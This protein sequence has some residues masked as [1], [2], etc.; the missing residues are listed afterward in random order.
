MG[1]KHAHELTPDEKQR[2][3][4]EKEK[5]KALAKLEKEQVKREK[6]DRKRGKKSSKKGD[7]SDAVSEAGSAWSDSTGS[8]PGSWYH[9]VSEPASLRSSVYLPTNSGPKSYQHDCW[10]SGY[11]DGGPDKSTSK[12]ASRASSKS[13]DVLNL[14]SGSLERYPLGV[15]TAEPI[16]PIQRRNSL[17]LS[18]VNETNVNK[19]VD[20]SKDNPVKSD[21]AVCHRNTEYQSQL[22]RPEIEITLPAPDQLTERN[23]RKWDAAEQHSLQSSIYYSADDGSSIASKRRSVETSSLGSIYYS[24]DEGSLAGSSLAGSIYYSATSGSEVGERNRIIEEE[25]LDAGRIV[26][27]N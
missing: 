23:K 16:D 15:P 27:S 22:T 3:K 12:P 26:F 25:F 8:A 24:A 7:G 5:E 17:D 2:L 21:S 19:G 20:E 4:F 11:E 9:S 10:Y 6:Q 13:H 18:Y 1:N 14:R